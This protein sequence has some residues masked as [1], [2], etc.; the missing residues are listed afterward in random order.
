LVIRPLATIKRRADG[1][2]ENPTN[3]A[4]SFVLNL[5]PST[6][7]C[8]SKIYLTTFRERSN[9]RTTSNIIFTLNSVSIRILLW[10]SDVPLFER[11]TSA[12]VSVI[13]K[14]RKIDMMIIGFFISNLLT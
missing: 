12:I 1:I 5:L 9:R 6:F 8:R 7:C 13:V 4:I 10:R 14:A 3:D 2:R 11:M